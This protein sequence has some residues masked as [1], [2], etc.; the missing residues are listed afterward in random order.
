MSLLAGGRLHDSYRALDR[1][2][3]LLKP[4]EQY[5]Q[6]ALRGFLHVEIV[7]LEEHIDEMVE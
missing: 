5:S 7:A 3:R 4:F 1:G 6:F 2:D